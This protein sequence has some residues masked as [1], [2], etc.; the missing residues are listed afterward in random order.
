[1]ATRVAENEIETTPEGVLRLSVAAAE[2]VRRALEGF[3]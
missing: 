3:A 1:M 2:R